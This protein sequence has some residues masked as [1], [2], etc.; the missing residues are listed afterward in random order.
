[1]NRIWFG[2]ILGVIFGLADMFI[3][4]RHGDQPAAALLQALTSRF[5]VGFPGANLSFP[6]HPVLTGMLAGALI[7]LPDAFG[8]K[9]C[10]GMYAPS[11]A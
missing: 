2:S 11:Q 1:M 10:S 6:W 8:L 5:A 3:T 7:S 4:M 9:S